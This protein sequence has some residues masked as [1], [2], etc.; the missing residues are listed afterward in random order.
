MRPHVA[1][2]SLKRDQ[3]SSVRCPLTRSM[4]L[5]CARAFD[6]DHVDPS[7]HDRHVLIDAIASNDDNDA[8]CP[9]DLKIKGNIVPQG[10]NRQ[11]L[12]V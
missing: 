2:R 12:C 8:T 6:G 11:K 1:P 3:I 4:V 5:I 9:A 7:P 10:R